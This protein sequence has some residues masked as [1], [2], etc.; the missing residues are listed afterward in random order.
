MGNSTLVDKTNNE[1]NKDHD[2]HEVLYMRS[3][4]YNYSFNQAK[5]TNKLEVTICY[6]LRALNLKKH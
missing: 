5:N 3:T 1:N 6:R 4:L 2:H